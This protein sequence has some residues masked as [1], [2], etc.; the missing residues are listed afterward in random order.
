VDSWPAEADERL[1]VMARMISAQAQ[2]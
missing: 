1:K 2:S